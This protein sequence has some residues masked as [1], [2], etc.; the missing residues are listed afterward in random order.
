M[1]WDQKL[2]WV[3]G[4]GKKWAKS[5]FEKYQQR[6]QRWSLITFCWPCWKRDVGRSRILLAITLDGEYI[7][8][9]CKRTIL[10][11]NN[12][13]NQETLISTKNTW[14]KP[15]AFKNAN[16]IIY[17]WEY[18]IS[19]I[20]P[21]F[22]SLKAAPRKISYIYYSQNHRVFYEFNINIT[23]KNDAARSNTYF[24]FAIKLYPN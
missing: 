23:P 1:C 21:N 19:R 12:K 10:I 20:M 7:Y 16:F 9:V 24:G 22:G 17:Q 11:A 5:C 14:V 8:S 2:R 13:S 18:S 4:G 15:A 6:H 3:E